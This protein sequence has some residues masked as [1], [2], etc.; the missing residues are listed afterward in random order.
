M[1]IFAALS[2][3]LLAACGDGA[4]GGSLSSRPDLP[5]RDPADRLDGTDSEGSSG[6]VL[7][8]SCLRQSDCASGSCINASLSRPGVCVTF[9]AVP[10]TG[11]LSGFPVERCVRGETCARIG[12]TGA[13]FCLR[14][15][16]TSAECPSPTVCDRLSSDSVGLFCVPGKASSSEPEVAEPPPVRSDA[17]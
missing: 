17:G 11:D 12:E 3:V 13:G 1:R 5:V 15:C 4:R 7:F 10:A 8:A 6:R 9:C 2:I 14:P 16:S